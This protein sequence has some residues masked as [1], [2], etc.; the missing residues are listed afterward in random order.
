MDLIRTK[1]MGTLMEVKTSLMEEHKISVTL[2]DNPIN[3]EVVK[4][5]NLDNQVAKVL[6][7]TGI[8]EMR[9]ERI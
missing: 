4:E 7:R 5:A 2:G 8:E 6:T 9:N 1:I 3:L